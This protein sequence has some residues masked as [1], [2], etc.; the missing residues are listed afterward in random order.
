[1]RSTLFGLV[2]AGGDYLAA[3]EGAEAVVFTGGIGENARRCGGGCATPWAGSGCGST[4]SNQRGETRISADV[5][6]LPVYVIL[7][8][9]E[10][11]IA[12]ETLALL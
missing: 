9:E 1:M 2:G 4:P 12:R 3:L 7:T 10:R 8:D 5:A 11:L 6:S